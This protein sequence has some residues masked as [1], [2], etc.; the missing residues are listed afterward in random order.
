MTTKG[1]LLRYSPHE[2]IRGDPAPPMAVI[3]PRF[4]VTGI[5]DHLEDRL[6]AG[7]H[8]GI[9]QGCITNGADAANA[10]IDDDTPRCVPSRHGPSAA[11]GICHRRT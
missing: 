11:A 3:P 6:L 10:V 8:E 5:V 7:G 1:G 9:M 4:K 2:P